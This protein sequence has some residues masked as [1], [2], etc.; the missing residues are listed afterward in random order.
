MLVQ[1]AVTSPKKFSNRC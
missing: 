1:N